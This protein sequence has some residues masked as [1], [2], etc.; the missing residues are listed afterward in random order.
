MRVNSGRVFS[1]HECLCFKASALYLKAFS[2]GKPAQASTPSR[3]PAQA[4]TRSCHLQDSWIHLGGGIQVSMCNP[5]EDGRNP[6][7]NSRNLRENSGNPS[8]DGSDQ[9]PNQYSS[10][11]GVNSEWNEAFPIE[12]RVKNTPFRVRILLGGAV[13]HS[14][15]TE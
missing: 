15:R 3:M 10:I 6:R 2:S 11:L 1:L 5:R 12:S 8:E 14:I 4:S 7:E 9:P 13:R